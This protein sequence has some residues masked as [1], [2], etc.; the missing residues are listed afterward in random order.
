MDALYVITLGGR[1]RSCSSCNRCRACC[2]LW[3]FSHAFFLAYATWGQLTAASNLA[4]YCMAALLRSADKQYSDD[5]NYSQLPKNSPLSLDRPPVAGRLLPA[6]L[7]NYRGCIAEK[8][9]SG[10]PR[11][12]AAAARAPAA[13]ALA[14]VMNYLAWMEKTGAHKTA[15]LHR[16]A[17]TPKLHEKKE[18][19]S[20]APMPGPHD[21]LRCLP[22]SRGPGLTTR[23]WFC[24]H[25]PNT[26]STALP[27]RM[28]PTT[29]LRRTGRSRRKAD[30]F[31]IGADR[32]IDCCIDS[33]GTRP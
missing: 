29:H 30:T 15:A 5:D 25:R 10:T 2:G 18:C 21:E 23:S 17:H 12:V 13:I 31:A 26:H 11:P 14:D 19:Q 32:L 1:P 4:Q 9:W 22:P 28:P 24:F 20:P 27:K 8:H 6:R 33:K 16:R 7:I 3:P